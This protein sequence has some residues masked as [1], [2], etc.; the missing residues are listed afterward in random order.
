MVR[1]LCARTEP[2]WQ[3]SVVCRSGNDELAPLGARVYAGVDVTR[4]E[5]VTAASDALAGAPIDLLVLA[6]GV[7]ERNALT[8]LDVASVRRQFEV[9]ALAPLRMVSTLLEQLAPGSK[10]AL[11]TSRMGSIAD[12]DSGSHY[13]YR[14]S[15]AALNAAGK[16]LAIDLAPRGIAVGVLH[17]GYVRTRM[18]GNTG[19]IDADESARLLLQ[20]IDEL[21]AGTSGSF[22]HANGDELP[23]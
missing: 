22:R 2:V 14:M 20:R 7:L 3:V 11:L 4:D 16:S 19:L 6:A 12:N 18:T 8:P 5:G 17:P 21:D 10:V 15:K 23:W 13:G 1:Q 9:N